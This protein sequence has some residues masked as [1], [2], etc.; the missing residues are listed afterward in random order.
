MRRPLRYTLSMLRDA[1]VEVDHVHEA[2]RHTEIVLENGSLYRVPKG[3]HPSRRHE[4]G[5]R[6]FIR[7]ILRSE[8]VP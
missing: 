1:G 3:N 6:S 4:R 2:T 5:L 8:A 7:K